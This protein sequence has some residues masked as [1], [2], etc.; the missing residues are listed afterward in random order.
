MYSRRFA[1][2]RMR[3]GLQIKI[4]LTRNEN[5]LNDFGGSASAE[6]HAKPKTYEFLVKIYL[7]IRENPKLPKVKFG[8]LLFKYELCNAFKFS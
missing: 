3:T 8:I 2:T 1:Y 7:K 5:S 6:F 4:L